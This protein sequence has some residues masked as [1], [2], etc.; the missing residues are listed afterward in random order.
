MLE[1]ATLMEEDRKCPVCGE[2]M[3]EKRYPNFVMWRCTHCRYRTEWQDVK[4]E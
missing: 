4:E 3:V 2:K 1:T